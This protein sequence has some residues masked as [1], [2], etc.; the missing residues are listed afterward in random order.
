MHRVP[1]RAII[2]HFVE[3]SLRVSH[4]DLVNT[5]EI[6]CDIHLAQNLAFSRE[7]FDLLV[8]FSLKYSLSS[9][10]LGRKV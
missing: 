10:S 1:L 4:L 9:V 8:Q 2:F 6:N 3:L 5:S 7:R